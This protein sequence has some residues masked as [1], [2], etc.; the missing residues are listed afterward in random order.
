MK[1]ARCNSSYY[2]TFLTIFLFFSICSTSANA[3]QPPAQP[4]AANWIAGP[5]HVDLGEKLA[6]L[7]LENGYIFANAKDTAA[8][9]EYMGN[10]PNKKELGLITP[11]EQNKNWFIVFRHYPVGYVKDDEKDSIDAAAIL[12][13][14]REGTEQANK[15]RAE[16]GVPPLTIKGWYQEPYYDEETHNLTWIILAPSRK[17]RRSSTT[18]SV[19]WDDRGTFPSCWLPMCRRWMPAWRNLTR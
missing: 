12:K 18:M 14:I 17:A 16:K 1:Q 13:A 4:P 8:L 3:S 9:L 6:D 15:I 11:N 2:Y 7:D 19:F 5:T 10:I